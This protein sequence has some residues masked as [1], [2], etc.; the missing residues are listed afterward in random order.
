VKRREFIAGLGGV[1]AWPMLARAQE[2]HMVQRVGVLMG[3]AESEPEFRSWLSTFVEEMRRLG[4]ADGRDVRFEVR[5]TNNDNERSQAFAHELVELKPDVI[6]ADTTP[7]TSAV[8]RETTTIPIVFAA[9]ADPIAAGFV[10]GFPRPLGNM[11]GFTSADPGMGG[12]WLQLIKEVAPNIKRAAAMYNPDGATYS[13][14]F[15]GS[16]KAAAQ[17][18]AVEALVT[19]VRSD[20]EI[21]AVINSLGGSAAGL[22]VLTNAFM[23]GHRA[24]VIAAAARNKIPSI[25]DVPFFP[26]DGGLLSYGP[27]FPDIFRRAAGYV[28]RILRGEKLADLPVQ[29]PVT[30]HL[31]INLKTAKAFG[32]TVPNTTLVAA[33]EVIE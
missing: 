31:A 4:W 11:T 32:L 26:R 16:F 23:G 12:K 33:D 19:L 20:D 25:F 22:V 28:D 27:S 6:L 13:E 9:V 3:R 24:A 5:W 1:T 29:A 17:S 10:V 15:L 21:E 30:Y 8:S 7:A 18:L 2:V 14:T